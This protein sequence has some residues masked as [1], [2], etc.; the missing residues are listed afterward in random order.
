MM[1]WF[2][3]FEIVSRQMVKHFTAWVCNY[4]LEVI[5]ELGFPAGSYTLYLSQVRTLLY[6][7]HYFS[8][9]PPEFQTF[10][11]PWILLRSWLYYRTRQDI[12]KMHLCV[13]WCVRGDIF[14][15]K[16]QKKTRFCVRLVIKNGAFGLQTEKFLSIMASFFRVF[17]WRKDENLHDSTWGG[18]VEFLLFRNFFLRAHFRA[19]FEQTKSAW[20][21]D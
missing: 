6:L 16:C 1:N 2:K 19:S 17:V 7:P 12:F 9:L 20:A 21:R 13:T 14:W 5:I 4:W 10:L 8:P 15:S 3:Q 11:Q 18:L